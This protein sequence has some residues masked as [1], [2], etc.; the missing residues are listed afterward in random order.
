[1]KIIINPKYNFL[2]N[3]IREIPENFTSG[4]EIIYRGRNEIRSFHVG[5]DDLV[6]KSFKIPNV[7]NKVVYG[8]FRPSKAK[9]SYENGIRLIENKLETPEPVAYIESFRCGCFDRSYYVSR[10]SLLTRHFRELSDL[11]Q[12]SETP[13]ILDEFARF[14]AELHEK[15][16]FHKDYTPGNILFDHVNRKYRFELID[17]NRMKFC[18]VD[19]KMGCKNFESLYIEDD[20]FR[21]L[22]QRYAFYRKYDSDACEKLVMKYRRLRLK[23]E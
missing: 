1:M 13:A 6:V 16:I 7:I 10:K 19:M 20:M 2:N 17:M 23:N 5:N 22:A 12:T 18:A 21:F 9:R 15:N 8:Y 4:G 3:F 11:P 14:S